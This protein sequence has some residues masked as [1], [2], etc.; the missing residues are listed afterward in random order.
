MTEK[1]ANT[2][3]N[4]VIIS[5]TISKRTNNSS[6]DPRAQKSLDKHEMAIFIQF[7]FSAS[8][9]PKPN[10][11]PNHSDDE[12]AG[13]DVQGNPQRNKISLSLKKRIGKRDN[14]HFME[15]FHGEINNENSPLKKYLSNVNKTGS[16]SQGHYRN[17]SYGAADMDEM[18]RN[19]E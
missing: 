5:R 17:P 11:K 3:N 8:T 4:D 9:G 14:R 13:D 10:P 16:K 18:R 15:S 12:S 19:L 1:K 2:G 6:R 7:V